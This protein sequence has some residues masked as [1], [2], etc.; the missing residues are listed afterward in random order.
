M[1]ESK[2]R[3]WRIL[4]MMNVLLAGC[5]HKVPV[6]DQADW[7]Q[8]KQHF[9]LADG[10]V[11]DDSR[12]HISHSE[13]QA[14]AM[15]L[16]VA[17]DDRATF[18][19]SWQWTQSHLSRRD[20]LFS[21][22]WNVRQRRVTDANDAVDADV[23]IAWALYR[24]SKRW[25]VPVYR[26]AA[27]RIANALAPLTIELGGLRF[28]LPGSRGF[29]RGKGA[30]LN[31]SYWIFPAYRELAEL[32]DRPDW[33]R[34]AR[35]AKRML[36]RM[37]FGAW[38]LAPDWVIVDRQGMALPANSRPHQFGYDA[39][40][41]P[42][43]LAWGGERDLLKPYRRFWDEFE[44]REFVPDRVNLRTDE[45]H[46]APGPGAVRDIAAL[47]RFVLGGQGSLPGIIH[48]ENKPTYYDASLSLLARVAWE[49]LNGGE[50]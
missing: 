8:Y 23:T 39:M 45:V 5:S 36:R 18:E 38:D 31:P 44:M 15:L 43:F 35:D 22:K 28:L 50:E 10:R 17:F 41:V 14:Y 13:G 9:I 1:S 40:R 20:G 29:R 34:L 24:A 21:W 49:E 32:T 19:R 27:E 48:W 30:M 4:L 3:I 46:M 33:H 25:N 11:R 37:Y 12:P 42:L 2:A 6:L 26:H 16:S 47:C 7:Q